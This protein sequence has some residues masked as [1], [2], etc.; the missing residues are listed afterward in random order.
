MTTALLAGCSSEIET[1]APSDAPMPGYSTSA[2]VSNALAAS[3]ITGTERPLE[4][5]ATLADPVD[6]DLK[7]KANIPEVAGY[8]IDFNMGSDTT[9]RI[10]D[11]VLSDVTT[12]RHPHLMP[13]TRFAYRLRPFFGKP[14]NVA[15]FDSGDAPDEASEDAGLA[16]GVASAG[17]AGTNSLR[18]PLASAGAAPSDL[19]ITRV[20]PRVADLNWKD[21]SD[22]EDGYLLEI[23]TGSDRGFQIFALLKTNTVSFRALTLPPNTKCYFRVLAFYE[24]GPSLADEKTTGAVPATDIP[25]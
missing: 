1:T 11:I 23:S 12:Y 20:A 7:W 25:K 6:V 15:S 16:P 2:V 9:F 5:T 3:A 19:R 4:L 18:N 21:N 24:G 8:F 10:L 13:N 14:S 17:E 22:D